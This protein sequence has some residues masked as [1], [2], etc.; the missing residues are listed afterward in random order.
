MPVENP[1][2]GAGMSP[3]LMSLPVKHYTMLF[4][5]QLWGFFFFDI[6]RGFAWF[7]NAK[8]FGLLASFYV[9]LLALGRRVDLAIF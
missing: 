6:E 3:L 9:L 1:S 4:R 7:W 8:I 5:P 2:L